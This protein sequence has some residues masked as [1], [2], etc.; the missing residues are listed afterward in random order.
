MYEC[1]SEKRGGIPLPRFS[2]VEMNIVIIELLFA[3]NME[4]GGT[5]S[6]HI[7]EYL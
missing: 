4:V 5:Q 3:A 2:I 7:S 6:I 1:S